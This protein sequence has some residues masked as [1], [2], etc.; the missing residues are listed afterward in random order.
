MHPDFIH[1]V[2]VPGYSHE[3]L[4]IPV[5]FSESRAE[6]SI[7]HNYSLRSSSS[8]TPQRTGT[9]KRNLPNRSALKD[10]NN[11]TPHRSNQNNSE[12]TPQTVKTAI[13]FTGKWP[14]VR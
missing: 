11:L 1:F 7:L 3:D 2:F 5:S 4:G 6:T 9:A 12:N 14:T 10:M 13:H 8:N